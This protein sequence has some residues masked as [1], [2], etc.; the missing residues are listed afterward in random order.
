MKH[1]KVLIHC[2]WILILH[3][4]PF[5]YKRNTAE[6]KGF[7][8]EGLMLETMAETLVHSRNKDG[9]TSLSLFLDAPIDVYVS[10]EGSFI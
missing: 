1:V 2:A 8:Q 4:G 10:S 6:I 7:S 5:R 3:A 9:L